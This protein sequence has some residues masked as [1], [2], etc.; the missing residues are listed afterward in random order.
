MDLHGLKFQDLCNARCIKH[1]HGSVV[2]TGEA[3]NLTSIS[4]VTELPRISVINA[5][6]KRISKNQVINK[7]ILILLNQIS[8]LSFFQE[9]C[10]YW[11][12]YL[13]EYFTRH[14]LKLLKELHEYVI[15]T[16][17]LMKQEDAIAKQRIVQP[18]GMP[19]LSGGYEK[20]QSEVWNQ[21]VFE[22]V[23]DLDTGLELALTDEELLQGAIANEANLMFNNKRL[24]TE[25]LLS[26]MHP[27]GWLTSES[28]QYFCNMMQEQ[29]P[30]SQFV[31]LN[32]CLAKSETRIL[33]ASEIN[34]KQTENIHFIF[35]RSH[36][37]LFDD[38]RLTNL[39]NH[40]AIASML[41][42]GTVV[43]GD[44]LYKNVPNN[45]MEILNDY[46]NTK[47]GR[48]ITK[49]ENIS[50]GRYFAKQRDGYLCG[51]IALM[52]LVLFDDKDVL[53][54]LRYS[55][56][57]P[58]V[59]PK[60][61]LIF[62]PSTYGYYLR[63]IF[64]TSYSENVLN[65]KMFISDEDLSFISGTIKNIQPQIRSKKGFQENFQNVSKQRTQN[66]TSESNSQTKSNRHEEDNYNV[67]LDD[68]GPDE[69]V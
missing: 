56:C 49:I 28:V 41:S 18:I 17:K 42:D 47:F 40:W 29:H 2:K 11:P 13:Q 15:K 43:F 10:I 25:S 63:Q 48:N 51:V 27:K 6:I 53:P 37:M 50:G 58:S 68:I 66:R 52:N 54:I 1:C 5:A 39:S 30:T 65:R 24:N 7:I 31:Y 8:F 23:L 38:S 3:T 44:S 67:Q 35:D 59:K 9:E 60:S 4:G 61:F 12:G 55:E 22:P 46:Y 14:D 19:N 62:T 36:N 16:R 26:L 32:Q 64:M 20:L 21:K 45:L 34:V 57:L 33:H 69:K